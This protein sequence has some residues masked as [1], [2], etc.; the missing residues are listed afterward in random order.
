ME[1]LSVHVPDL[2]QGVLSRRELLLVQS[3]RD[4]L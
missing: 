1:E 2:L 3:G 4:V